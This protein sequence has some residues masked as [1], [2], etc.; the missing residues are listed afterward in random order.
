[1][2]D[3][4]NSNGVYMDM[5][6][7]Y[8][9][10]VEALI[11]S[12]GVVAQAQGE[13]SLGIDQKNEAKLDGTNVTVTDGKSEE[14]AI[15]CLGGLPVFAEERGL[16]NNPHPRY[17]ILIDPLDGTRPFLNGA[18]TSTVIMALYD[19]VD[20]QVVGCFV[21]EPVSGRVWH[22]MPGMDSTRV[23]YVAFNGEELAIMSQVP[24]SVFTGD[25]GP[26]ITVYSDFYPGFTKKGSHSFSNEEQAKLFEMIFGKV[27]AISM[28]G[29]NAIHHALVA[30]GNKHDVAGAITTCLGGAWDVAPVILVEKAGGAVRGFTRVD[31]VWEEQSP[32]DIK[33]HHFT[34][35]GNSRKTVDTLSNI[36]TS[37]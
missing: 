3:P 31:G 5:P 37:I 9:P 36:L 11:M 23:G 20:K 6:T 13:T 34:I 29:S 1:M 33:A 28:L 4:L 26:K 10:M 22:Y 21:G 2:S 32:L 18:P 17:E 27:S 15:V 16:V 25:L 24:V 8:Q 35:S 7:F 14:A 19:K 30:M 12:M